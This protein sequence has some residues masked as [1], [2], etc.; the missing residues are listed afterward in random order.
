[1]KAKI[2]TTLARNLDQ[3]INTGKIPGSC[4]PS[5]MAN[6]LMTDGIVTVITYK[7]KRVY[8]LGRKEELMAYLQQHYGMTGEQLEEWIA[9]RSKEKGITRAEQVNLTGDSKTVRVRTFHGF[10]AKTLASLEVELHGEP[11]TLT[12]TPGISFFI[13]D[14]ES[15]H[16]PEDVTVVGIENGENFQLIHKQKDLFAGMKTLFV[17]RYPQSN[18]LVRWLLSIPNPYLH[19]GDFDLAGIAIYLHEFYTHLKGRASFFIPDDIESRLASHGNTQLYDT[20]YPRYGK[21]EVE[22]SGVLPLWKLIHRYHC[23]YEQEGYIPL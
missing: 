10:P 13:E 9:V 22:D 3:L 8:K 12:P 15:L 21:M 11:F 23:G 19:F 5:R 18:D 6:D 16:I 20:Q 4:L 7:S 2:S 1:M 17:C 14:Y